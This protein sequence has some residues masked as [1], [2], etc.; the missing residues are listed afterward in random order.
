MLFDLIWS[1]G[2]YGW[3]VDRLF[4]IGLNCFLNSVSNYFTNCSTETKLLLSG[5]IFEW[6]WQNKFLKWLG[7][8]FT[9]FTMHS[10]GEKVCKYLIGFNQVFTHLTFWWKS[11]SALRSFALIC[12]LL[13]I[14]LRLCEKHEMHS[15]NLV[16]ANL[17]QQHKKFCF[18]R[19]FLPIALRRL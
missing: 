18:C 19:C 8:R 5:I 3:S 9:A 10:V 11:L 4:A 7:T 6:F 12:D 14:S 17:M 1:L 2:R 16:L 13:N 15:Q